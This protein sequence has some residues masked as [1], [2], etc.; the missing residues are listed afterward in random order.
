MKQHNCFGCNK[1][2]KLNSR[3]YCVKCWNLHQEKVCKAKKLNKSIPLR[4]L[5]RWSLKGLIEKGF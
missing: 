2:K 3:G 4:V 5:K 1:E